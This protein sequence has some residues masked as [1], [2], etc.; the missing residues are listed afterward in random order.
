VEFLAEDIGECVVAGRDRLALA[1]DM[2]AQFRPAGGTEPIAQL[3]SDTLLDQGQRIIDLQRFLHARASD[4][5][6]AVALDLGE[7]VIGESDQSLA[8]DN[9]ADGENLGEFAFS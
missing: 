7:T 3:R 4:E 5:S 2:L 9:A 8:Y 1:F 6:A